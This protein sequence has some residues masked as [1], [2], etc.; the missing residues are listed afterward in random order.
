MTTAV[1]ERDTA[2]APEVPAP[3]PVRVPVAME[4]PGLEAVVRAIR[5]TRIGVS[6]RGASK[7]A[8]E[9]VGE[10]MSATTMSEGV[11]VAVDVAVTSRRP[12]RS[13]LTTTT[14]TAAAAGAPERRARS[15]RLVP[16]AAATA[17]VMMRMVMAAV[18]GVLGRTRAADRGAGW[19]RK[20]DVIFDPRET[21][22]AREVP[23]RKRR[24]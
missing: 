16:P 6:E 13:L 5:A 21:E 14:T 7:G 19:T 4:N 24:C 20:L 18:V 15:P 17:K 3:M 23:L 2:V 22:S 10:G 8:S 1:T 12:I 11:T 9:G